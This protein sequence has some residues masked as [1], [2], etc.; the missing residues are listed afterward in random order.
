MVRLDGHEP[1]RCH[2]GNDAAFRSSRLLII[3][4]D[5]PI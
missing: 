4:L 5:D 3:M 1:I 2:S